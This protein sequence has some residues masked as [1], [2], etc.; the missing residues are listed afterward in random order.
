[1]SGSSGL[2]LAYSEYS[3]HTSSVIDF[4]M[5]VNKYD[6]TSQVGFPFVLL[7]ATCDKCIVYLR[8]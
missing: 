3:V 7:T 8:R 1:M 2:L 6:A 5:R 4:F